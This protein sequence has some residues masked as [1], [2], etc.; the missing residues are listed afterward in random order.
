MRALSTGAR[1]RKTLPPFPRR[2]SLTVQLIVVVIMV[3]MSTEAQSQQFQAP[4]YSDAVKGVMA[5][6][7]RPSKDSTPVEFGIDD[8]HYKAPRN[9]IVKMD[10]YKGGPQ[11]TVFFQ[12]TFPGFEPLTDKTEQC[13]LHTRAR[14]PQGCIPVRFWIGR[15]G[16]L[17]VSDEDVFERN[18]RRY[19][20]KAPNLDANGFEV[21]KNRKGLMYRKKTA[22]HMLVFK[23]QLRD[24][25]ELIRTMGKGL[26]NVYVSPLPGNINGLSYIFAYERINDAEGIDNGIRDLLESFT[27]KGEK[28]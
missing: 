27:I 11:D 12:A 16:T 5:F 2:V 10:N 23:C 26:C 8:M 1:L 9:Y 14:E 4:S 24:N 28:P 13:F 21:Y 20:D 18:L 15:Y 17:F 6:I 3:A 25:E 19:P 7:D 22:K